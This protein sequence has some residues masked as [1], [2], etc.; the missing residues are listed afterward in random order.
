[1]LG[2]VQRHL[3]GTEYNLA[4]SARMVSAALTMQVDYLEELRKMG[5]KRRQKL[6]KPAIRNTI[7]RLFHVSPH[8][9]SKIM[10]AF[11][12]DRTIYEKKRGGNEGT[13][14]NA[15]IWPTQ[16]NVFV[17]RDFVRDYRLQRKRVTAVQV[18]AHLIEKGILEVPTDSLGP[19]KRKELH[20]AERCVQRFVRKIGY[21]RGRK[22]TLR[23]KADITAKRDIYLKKYMANPKEEPTMRLR[24]VYLD[25]SYVH[26]HYKWKEDDSLFDPL[27]EFAIPEG[28]D[29]HKGERYCF[30]CAIQGPSPIQRGLASDKAG[31]VL[32]SEWAFS[33]TRKQDHKGDYHKVFNGDNFVEWFCDQLL[34]NL[35]EAS[36]II[37]DNAKYHAVSGKHVP[38]VYNAKRSEL[39]TYLL[40]AGVAFDADETMVMLKKKAREHINNHEQI[41]IERL[42]NE[43]GHE[44]LWTPP[45]YSDLQPIELV[46]AWMK[47][48]IGRQY[49]TNTTLA[50]V[51]ERLLAQFDRLQSEE[52]SV[53]VEKVINKYHSR[54]E[55]L[56]TKICEAEAVNKY[57]EDDSW[58]SSS[59]GS[60]DVSN[61]TLSSKSSIELLS[62]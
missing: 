62:V 61:S 58:D 39:T 17:V 6:V 27:D 28:K 5:Q 45:Y 55:E 35:V 41:E 43:W 31:M 36:I 38:K 57:G 49:D 10:T 48:A 16:E 29:K 59:S 52:G 51:Y 40:S 37:L 47:G 25:E 14:I 8:T 26:H 4:I 30:I 53:Y 54:C 7:C 13:P 2:E 60:D 11:L 44:I 56:W 24:E 33:P 42:A 34:P 20:A 21:E 50:L 15:R 3:N 1:M 32:Q 9:Y 18:T 46:W 23:P 22:K 12:S 19:Y